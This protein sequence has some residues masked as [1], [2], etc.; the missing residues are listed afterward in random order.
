MPTSWS[1]TPCTV[2]KWLRECHNAVTK[3]GDGDRTGLDRNLWREYT[4][5]LF[6]EDEKGADPLLRYEDKVKE[7]S[8]AGLAKD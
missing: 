7:F 4:E 2:Q 6:P 8:E 1:T 5:K 3:Q